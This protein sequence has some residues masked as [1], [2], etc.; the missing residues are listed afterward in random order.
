MVHLFAIGGGSIVRPPRKPETQA[1][2]QAIVQACGIR[3][4]H[5][6]FLPTASGDSARYAE[7]F[8]RHY[9]RH[10]ECRVSVLNVLSERQ[11]PSALRAWIDSADIIY[12]GGGNTLRMMK[13]W[14]ALGLDRLLS[15]A[16]KRGTIV[17]G[18]SAGCICWFREGHSDSLQYSNPRAPYIRVRGLDLVDLLVCPHF[19]SEPKR[20]A[21]LHRKIRRSGT[22]ALGLE[23]GTALEVSGLRCRI[24]SSLPK[25][26][27]WLLLPQRTRVQE[28]VIP[29]DTWFTVRGLVDGRLDAAA[30]PGQHGRSR[31]S[32]ASGQVR[33]NRGQ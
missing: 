13:R 2:D 17:S 1:I 11:S 30:V 27:A 23:N 26:H 25:A 18:L 8:S 16:A 14:R 7:A 19:R 22:V 10:L 28:I 5:V 15:A 12:V 24:I 9:T 33:Q 4:P 32:S 21:D 29:A 31:K 20:R 6:L 3:H